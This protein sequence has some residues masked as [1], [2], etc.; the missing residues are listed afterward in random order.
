ME[1]FTTICLTVCGLLLLALIGREIACWYW[2]VNQIIRLLE[3]IAINTRKDEAARAP[4]P[5]VESL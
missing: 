4:I 1:N 3:E 5:E 2:K